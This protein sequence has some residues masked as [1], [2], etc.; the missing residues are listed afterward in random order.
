MRPERMKIWTWW[1][2]ISCCTNLG[3]QTSASR[4]PG[5]V[6][7]PLGM[8][9]SNTQPVK[10][11]GSNGIGRNDCSL[12]Q[13]GPQSCAVC[14]S[15]AHFARKTRTS[16]S[17][18]LQVCIYYRDL[19]VLLLLLLLLVS[20]VKKAA[21]NQLVLEFFGLLVE[22]VGVMFSVTLGSNGSNN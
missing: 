7:S 18:V 20:R 12:Q 9:I 6:L 2:V 5:F 13:P 19:L 22:L 1:N 15:Q 16:P 14:F 10:V 8:G 17:H 11:S 3:T 21:R 4:V